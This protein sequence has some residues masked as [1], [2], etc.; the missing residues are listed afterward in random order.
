MRRKSGVVAQTNSREA[1]F[2]G[3]L[4]PPINRVIYLYSS[5]PY[6][7]S[8]STRTEVAPS[9]LY[10]L[11]SNRFYE[12]HQT[13][14]IPI[15][16]N[17]LHHPAPFTHHLRPVITMA[18]PGPPPGAQPFTPTPQQIQQMIAMEAQKRGMT[19]PQFQAFQ[20]QQIE[21]EA[22][23]AGM[24][25]QQFVQ[26]KQEEARQQFLRQQ[27]Q[28]QQAQAQS[29]GQGQPGQPGQPRPPPGQQVQQIPVNSNVEPTPAALAVARFL[30]NQDL[31]T[32]T[33]IFNGERKDMFKGP[34]TVPSSILQK[35]NSHQ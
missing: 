14:D 13:L 12:T 6:P 4:P 17:P 22:A 3:R 31:K 21:T 23:K 29:Q 24:T 11:P 10:L 9:F 16:S 20:R 8:Q 30:R 35:T 32:R 27:Q 25:P 18:S 7:T 34:A 28:Q 1:S 2:F 33:C 15:W 19:I 5:K 26:M